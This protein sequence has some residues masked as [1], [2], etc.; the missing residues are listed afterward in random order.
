MKSE[1][2]SFLIKDGETLFWPPSDANEML[3]WQTLVGYDNQ[4]AKIVGRSK[5]SVRE[6]RLSHNIA[7][8]S[9]NDPV[10]FQT[11]EGGTLF[12]PPR[13][14]DEMLRWQASYGS[15]FDIAKIV[16][17]SRQA[18]RDVRRSLNVSAPPRYKPVDLDSVHPILEHLERAREQKGIPPY[19]LSERV[20]TSPDLWRRLMRDNTYFS[21]NLARLEAMA[22]ILGYKLVLVPKD[23]LED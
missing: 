18:V 15:D 6:V 19:R 7:A 22:D 21:R 16:H 12:W 2:R 3:R 23:P 8:K 1:K 14:A 5:Q 9:Y 11:H 17:R 4:I 10:E 20:S 13:D